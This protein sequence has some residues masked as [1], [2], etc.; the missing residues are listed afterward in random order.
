MVKAVFTPKY[1]I[2]IIPFGA[3]ITGALDGLMLF[4]CSCIDESSRK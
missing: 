1:F 2:V 4:T 3:L